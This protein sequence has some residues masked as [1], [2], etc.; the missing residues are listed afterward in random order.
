MLER[1][2]SKAKIADILGAHRSTIYRE[3]K[4]NSIRLSQ[5]TEKVYVKRP[6]D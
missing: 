3:I 1:R 5:T 2:Y 6:A 4:R